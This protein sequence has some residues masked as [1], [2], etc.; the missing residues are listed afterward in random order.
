MPAPLLVLGFLSL[1]K[2]HLAHVTGRVVPRLHAMAAATRVEQRHAAALVLPAMEN[3][4]LRRENAIL[5]QKL[6]E[7]AQSQKN[8]LEALRQEN[9]CLATIIR[10]THFAYKGMTVAHSLAL[11]RAHAQN[12]FVAALRDLRFFGIWISH[13]FGD[14]KVH[15]SLIGLIWQVRIGLRLKK[16]ADGFRPTTP[17]KS[18]ADP[19]APAQEMG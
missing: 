8:A 11:C 4:D 1:P 18:A 9:D 16:L 2:A 19:F 15:L 17:R 5:Q 7:A 12:A 6:D 14:L 3:I 10:R 13:E